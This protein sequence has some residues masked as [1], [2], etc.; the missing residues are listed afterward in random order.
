MDGAIM[1]KFLFTTSIRTS[2]IRVLRPCRIFSTA[3]KITSLARASPLMAAIS[4]SV[5]QE[6]ILAGGKQLFSLTAR[7]PFQ[8]TFT[9]MAERRGVKFDKKSPSAG[10]PPRVGA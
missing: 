10:S 4:W 2:V 6:L 3:L 7:Q 8:L 9:R 1:E 5:C